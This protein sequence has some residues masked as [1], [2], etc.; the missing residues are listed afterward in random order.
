M[1]KTNAVFTECTVFGRRRQIILRFLAGV[2][3]LA[4]LLTFACLGASMMFAQNCAPPS[5]FVDAPHPAI[6]APERLVSHTEEIVINRSLPIVLSAVDKPI[7]DTIHKSGSLPGVSGEYLLTKAEFG[8][9]GSRRITCLS[10]GTTLEEEVLG[11]ERNEKSSRFRYI[12]WNYTTEKARPISYGIG[13]FLYTDMG[14]RRTHIT[15]VYSFKLREDKFPG[16]FGAIGRF[17]FRVR[18]L[19]K[20]YAALMRDVLNGYK[21]D[22]EQR[23]ADDDNRG[24]VRN[25][26]LRPT[27]EYNR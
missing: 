9:S 25:P 2:R 10:D 27:D 14:D 17:L 16:N 1:T 8:T 20:D 23:P 18:F 13:D 19:D 5:G 6:D 4:L 21:T 22:A 7:K 3:P 26:P 15:W 24:R 11:S 12:V